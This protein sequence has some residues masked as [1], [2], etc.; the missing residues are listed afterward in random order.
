MEEVYL[1]PRVHISIPEVVK[2]K[3]S[4]HNWN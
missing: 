3:N 2:Y 4:T 1:R